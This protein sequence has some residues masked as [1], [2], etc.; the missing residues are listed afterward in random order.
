[1][2]IEPNFKVAIEHIPHQEVRDY[3]FEEVPPIGVE[4]DWRSGGSDLAYS[5]DHRTAPA[6]S[7][8]LQEVSIS[9]PSK[10]SW[11]HGP[12]PAVARH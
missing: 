9:N 7:G 4:P 8:N 2:R 11:F 6:P 5:G 12:A 1:M 10:G 3:Y